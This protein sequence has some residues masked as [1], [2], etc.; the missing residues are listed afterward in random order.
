MSKIAAVTRTKLK[1]W[2]HNE[3]LTLKQRPFVSGKLI[4]IVEAFTFVAK[5]EFEVQIETE[6]I[7]FIPTRS[8]I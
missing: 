4:N 8:M 3:E 2:A 6:E 5:F 7:N 1:S